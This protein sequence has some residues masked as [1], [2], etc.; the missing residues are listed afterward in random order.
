ML[1]HEWDPVDAEGFLEWAD[2]CGFLLANPRS[3]EVYRISDEGQRVV[4]GR[5]RVLAELGSPTIGSSTYQFWIDAN[6]D[7]V[8][9]FRSWEETGVA[10]RFYVDG[11]TWG[12][13]AQVARRA[14]QFSFRMASL[15]AIVVDRSGDS[16]ETDWEAVVAGADE[17][18]DG[19]P[20]FAAFSGIAPAL[21]DVKMQRM[22][23]VA[24]FLMMGQ[25]ERIH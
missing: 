2:E 18:L 11:L 19:V 9:S 7:I 20:E 16:E 3:R 25:F 23:S 22:D 24:D 12:Q 21:R 1:F 5:E 10:I 6:V 17:D 4:E 13:R 8:C 14:I 15:R